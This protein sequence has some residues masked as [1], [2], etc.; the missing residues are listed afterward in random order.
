[1][2]IFIPVLSG[3]EMLATLEPYNSAFTLQ[4]ADLSDSFIHMIASVSQDDYEALESA[5][6]NTTEGDQEGR[7]WP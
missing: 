3:S 2:T 4:P 5:E 6:K 1:M 7:V